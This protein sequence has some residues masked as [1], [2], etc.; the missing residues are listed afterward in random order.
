MSLHLLCLDPTMY[1]YVF[2]EETS[3][4]MSNDNMITYCNDVSISKGPSYFLIHLIVPFC[5]TRL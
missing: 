5:F 4:Y 2:L 1:P 3:L